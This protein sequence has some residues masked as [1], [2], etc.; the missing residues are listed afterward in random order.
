MTGHLVY[1]ALLVCFTAV[2]ATLGLIAARVTG[3][4]T[5]MDSHDINTCTIVNPII[6]TIFVLMMLTAPDFVTAPLT[7]LLSSLAVG[8]AL[9]LVYLLGWSIWKV[10]VDFVKFLDELMGASNKD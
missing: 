3:R 2:S 8:F 10:G 5:G 9:P 4:L 7:F 1:I 6:T